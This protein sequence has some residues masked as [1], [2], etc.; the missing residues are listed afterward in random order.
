M[1]DLAIGGTATT[2]FGLHLVRCE[3]PDRIETL[4]RGAT[5][6]ELEPNI[7]GDLDCGARRGIEHLGHLSE[8]ALAGHGV[9][10]LPGPDSAGAGERH[11]RR[12]LVVKQCM[13]GL[14]GSELDDREAQ[15]LPTSIAGVD[16]ELDTCTS[17]RAIDMLLFHGAP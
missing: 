8:H 17:G 12:L 16:I 9:A 2:L 14:A 5:D 13:M 3:Q 6:R 7:A 1:T 15:I 4:G 10:G 11:D